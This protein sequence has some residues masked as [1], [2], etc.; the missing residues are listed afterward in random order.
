MIWNLLVKLGN[1]PMNQSRVKFVLLR[2]GTVNVSSRSEMMRL[3]RHDSVCLYDRLQ[4]ESYF[5]M[6]SDEELG[7]TGLETF[8]NVICLFWSLHC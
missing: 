7:L 5:S 2:C 8:S 1:P 4:L 6:G 3:Q